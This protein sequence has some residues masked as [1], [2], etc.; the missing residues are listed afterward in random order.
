VDTGAAVSVISQAIKDQLFP[1]C[2]LKDTSTKLTTYTGEQIAVAGKIKVEV[3]YGHQ[4]AELPLFVVRGEGPSLMGRDWLQSIRLDWN[5]ICTIT[6]KTRAEEFMHKYPEVFKEGLGEMNTFSATLK[7]KQG[8]TP[9]F[10]KARPVP[11]A[12]KEAIELELDRLETEGIIEKVFTILTPMHSHAHS[13]R[14]MSTLKQQITYVA[15]STAKQEEE[16]PS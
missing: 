2:Q 11:F 1:D 8:S 13:K 7:M 9:R 12:L 5:S 14:N 15:T 4:R 3:R 6:S 16:L 10:V